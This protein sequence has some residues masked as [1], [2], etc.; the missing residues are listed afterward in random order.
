M[1]RGPRIVDTSP[2]PA[3]D[4]TLDAVLETLAEIAKAANA[5]SFVFRGEPRCYEDISSSLYRRYKE[6]LGDFGAEGFDIREVQDEILVDAARYAADLTPPDLLSQLQ[7]YGYPTNL[8]D[9]T[10]D[11]L[12]A[13]FFAC[14]SEPNDDGRIVLL[15]SDTAPLFRMRSPV[16]RIKAQKSVFVNPPSGIVTADHTINVPSDLKR[17]ILEYLERNHDIRTNTIYDDIHGFIKNADV[18]R[19]AYAEFHFGGLYMQQS[20]F[21]EALKHYNSSIELNGRLTASY[22]NRGLARFRLGLYDESIQD[23]TQ[24]ISIDPHDAE[25]FLQRGRAHFENGRAEPAEKD[26]SEAIRLDEKLEEAYVMRA[27]ARVQL[28]DFEGAFEDLNRVI[29]INPMNVAAYRGRSAVFA[30]TG[31]AVAAERD[32]DRAI[33]LDPSDAESY[34]VRALFR[35]DAGEYEEALDDYSSYIRLGGARS[36]DAYFR[37]GVLLLALDRIDE[38]RTDLKTAIKLDP[39]AVRDALRAQE[40]VP[41]SSQTVEFKSEIPADIV[42]M[43]KI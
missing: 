32:V 25:A 37:R 18:H 28:W 3:N 14:D 7:H 4:D 17:P 9:F 13:L 11:Y 39:N 12:I 15:N 16:N 21:E 6:S 2:E 31:D 22:V 34:S 43:L 8:I 29:D 26:C 42:E 23:F 36:A 33:K 24:V 1:T 30:A 10:T 27:A 5:G 20:K 19:S 35:F 41:S 38:A 40:N